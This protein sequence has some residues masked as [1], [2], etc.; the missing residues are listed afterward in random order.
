MNQTILLG[1]FIAAF[2]TLLW[3]RLD[4]IDKRLEEVNKNIDRLS[5]RLTSLIGDF[6]EF[7]GKVE[8]LLTD[9]KPAED[10]HVHEIEA[11]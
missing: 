8:A 9:R 6:R 3:R 1:A 5:D 2:F 11:K 4:G 10:R 7:K